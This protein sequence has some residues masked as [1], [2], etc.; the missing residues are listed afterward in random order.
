MFQV[1]PGAPLIVAANR[2]ELYERP[3]VA[4][5]ALRETGPRILGGR[6]ELA[7]GTWLAVSEHGQVA[8]LTNQPSA[9]GRDPTKRSRG[10]LPVFFAS[11]PSA[12]QAVER[13]TAALHPS[14]YNPCWMLVGDRNSL[15]SV[16]I[17]GGDQPEVEQPE[18]EQ[19]PPGLHI[20]VNA[21]L[22]ASS[23]KVDRVA[24]LID[25]AMSAQPDDSPASAVAAL[26]AVLR[27]HEPAVKEPQ[28]T[29]AG[30]VRPPEVSAACVHTPSH[31]TRSA[32]TVCVPTAGTPRIRF[33]D[34]H[35]CEVPMRD[36]SGLWA[37]AASAEDG[38]NESRPGP[39]RRDGAVHGL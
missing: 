12:A 14:D 9:E 38:G 24:R 18:V 6:D 35:P 16:G 39:A 31:G 30:W 21:P 11:Y 37:A 2:D 3:T 13:V 29:S 26:E 17:A 4:M 28:V 27:D 8:G 36:V 22:R 15:F 20:L 7:G 5:A 23:A 19:L 32:T 25:E 1:V 34:G 10:E 33:A